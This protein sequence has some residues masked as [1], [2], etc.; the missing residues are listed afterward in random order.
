MRS[1][2]S[3]KAWAKTLDCPVIHIDGTLDWRVNAKIIVEQFN[4]TYT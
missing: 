4:E 1:L 3:Q 2:A